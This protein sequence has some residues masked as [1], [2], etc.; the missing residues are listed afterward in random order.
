MITG[1]LI[2]YWDL[3]VIGLLLLNLIVQKTKWKGDDDMLA[4]IKS[5]IVIL[6]TGKPGQ[7]P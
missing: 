4:I 5:W 3:V 1:I 7:L 2:K 6:F